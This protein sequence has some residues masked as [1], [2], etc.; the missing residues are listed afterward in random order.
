MHIEALLEE[1]AERF[2]V[3]GDFA[4]AYFKE[5]DDVVLKVGL[6]EDQDIHCYV[7]DRER[8]ITLDATLEQFSPYDP[9]KYQNDLWIGDEHPH[10]EELGES[11]DLEEY[12]EMVDEFF[13]EV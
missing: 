2:T 8:D 3:C 7:Y 12:D 4:E 5:H 9:A 6:V 11:E 10:L 1:Y 13:W